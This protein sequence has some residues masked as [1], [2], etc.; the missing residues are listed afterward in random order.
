MPSATVGSGDTL[1]VRQIALDD[2]KRTMLQPD[3]T[4]ISRDLIKILTC[5]AICL[6]QRLIAHAF[7]DHRALTS[8]PSGARRNR[9]RQVCKKLYIRLNTLRLAGSATAIPFQ[10][11]FVWHCLQP[12]VLAY[13]PRPSPF[14]SRFSVL[15]GKV[16]STQPSLL[17]A[18]MGE[19]S[20]SRGE[21]RMFAETNLWYSALIRPHNSAFPSSI[22]LPTAYTPTVVAGVG[23]S[24]GQPAKYG[25]QEALAEPWVRQMKKAPHSRLSYSEML[26][27]DAGLATRPSTAF[28]VRTFESTDVQKAASRNSRS[29]CAGANEA[30][31]QNEKMRVMFGAK[32]VHRSERGRVRRP[33]SAG[34]SWQTA[35]VGRVSG[36]L[37]PARRRTCAPSERQRILLR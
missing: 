22:N 29:D 23:V 3:G 5:Y 18:H 16:L 4:D 12:S 2:A 30:K 1:H 13:V 14:A 28:V 7:T 32:S 15:S 11:S 21:G 17:S 24:T 9:S 26:L 36:D 37:H 10:D 34:H 20:T 33:R 6:P 35:T 27:R 25:K 31:H 19:A 8:Y